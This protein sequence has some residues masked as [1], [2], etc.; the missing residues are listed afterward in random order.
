M[1]K[2]IKVNKKFYIPYI[3]FLCLSFLQ[4]V[5]VQAE[6]SNRCKNR[7]NIILILAD[8]LGYNGLRCYGN[9]YVNTP[10]IDKLCQEGMKFTKGYAAAPTCAPSRAAIMSGQYSPR[11]EVY[12]VKE[13][14]KGLEEFMPVLIPPDA[15]HLKP[16]KV[17]IAEALKPGG[18]STAMFGKWHLGYKAENHPVHQGFDVAIESHGAH[19]NFKTDP[20]VEYPEG[21]YVGD[22]FTDKAIEFVGDCAKKDKPFFLYMPYFLIHGPFEAKQ[23]YLDEC[24]KQ[25]PGDFPEKYHYWAAMTKSLDENVGR[26]MASLKEQGIDEN[27]FVIFTSD[28][29]GA[30]DSYHL[31]L[32]NNPL[33]MFKGETYEG[34]IRVPYI[35]RWSGKIEPG[36]VCDEPI[37]GID[38]YPTCLKAAGVQKPV[39][40][41]LDGLD[42]FPCL[43]SQGMASLN[44]DAL[45]WYYP[46][47]AGYNKK[48]GKW[49]DTWR[50]VI[51][52]GNYK[53]IEYITDRRLELFD[54]KNDISEKNNLAKKIPEKTKELKNKLDN[55]K[56]S[57]KAPE[58]IWNQQ[59]NKVGKNDK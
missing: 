33:R 36:T 50:N 26:L 19:F 40:Y 39:N 45:Y 8:D 59:K 18:Y 53:L 10:N 41:P 55:W 22:F 49:K 11:T 4:P 25:L 1:Y 38:L 5:L 7:P 51:I 15:L 14:H 42:I 29:G 21:A 37:H 17:T 57:L 31:N 23:K 30:P 35:F 54:I 27:T 44:R 9:P 32:F 56:K 6:N 12:R 47:S 34:G 28:N 43:E 3:L 20:K 52:T 13:H 24:K 16:E 2:P 48:T 46:K 58:P